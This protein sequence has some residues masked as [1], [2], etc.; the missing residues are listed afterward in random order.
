VKL[1]VSREVI[2]KTKPLSII[3]ILAAIGRPP[4]ICLG[5][6]VKFAQD[7]SLKVP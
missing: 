5:K 1:Q 7:G 6:A 3:R 2:G 4:G